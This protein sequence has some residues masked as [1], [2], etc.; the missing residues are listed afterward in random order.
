MS[1]ALAAPLPD[2]SRA[3]GRHAIGRVLVAL[4]LHADGAGVCWPSAETIAR[5]VSGLSRRDVRN[6][7]D[8]LQAAG[9][10]ECDGGHGRGRV[11]RWRL[12]AGYPATVMPDQRRLSGEQLAGNPATSEGPNLAGN[13]AG[14]LA[15]DMAGELAGYPAPNRTELDGKNK[16]YRSS[17]P[18]L[19]LS[20]SGFAPDGQHRQEAAS[21]G[22]D[23]D[24]RFASFRDIWQGHDGH[25]RRSANWGA[26]FTA[27]LRSSAEGREEAT[28]HA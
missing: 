4:A 20:S 14:E 8:A 12:L 27:Y 16:N 11:R 1:W 17:A 19:T 13:M 15:G 18:L 22:L 3:I 25:E 5:E 6:A 21:L 7:L 26:A 10:I 24:E 2:G 9:L 23:V 28:F